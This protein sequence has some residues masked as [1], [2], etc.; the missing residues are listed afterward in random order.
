MSTRVLFL[1]KWFVKSGGIERV[2]RNLAEALT[3]QGCECFFY[4]MNHAAEEEDGFLQLS[5]K[6]ESVRSRK[7]ASFWQ[8][9]T[10]VRAVIKIHK[11]DA[12]I[13]ATEQANVLAFVAKLLTKK[14]TVTYTRH[15]AFDVSDQA[16]P[17]WTIRCFYSLFALNGNIVAVSNALKTQI[18]RSVLLNKKAVH[19]I[20]NAVL[21]KTMFAKAELAHELMPQTPYFI[22]IGRLAEQKGFDL[23]LQAYARARA[24]NERLPDLLILGEGE[25]KNSLASLAGSLNIEQYV[26]FAGFTG[27]PYPCIKQAK[28]FVL[29]SRHEGMPTVL[30]ESLALETPVI[31]FDCP[32][33]PREIINDGINGILVEYLNVDKLLE[34]MLAFETLPQEN[35][36]SGVQQF[37]YENVASQYLALCTGRV[38]V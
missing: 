6:F 22:A 19:F 10:D 24:I 7:T 26:C 13:S 32:T 1:H 14:L 16:L 29:S 31:A 27:N 4:V 15:C 18:Q 35:L 38:D 3:A 25:L 28:A 20:P 9:L 30:I 21:S 8:K 36:S 11:I 12:V 37:S 5:T 23:L 33:G 2:H 17:A 34:A